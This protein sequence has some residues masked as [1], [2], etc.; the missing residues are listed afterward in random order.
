MSELI[1]G[2]LIGGAAV[3]VAIMLALRRAASKPDGKTAKIINVIQGG[4]GGTP[5][6]PR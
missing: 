1:L 3:A 2:L 4:G 6:V 5:V